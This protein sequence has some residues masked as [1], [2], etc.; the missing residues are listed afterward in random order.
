MAIWK[1]AYSWMMDVKSVFSGFLSLKID[2]L[3]AI[4]WRVRYQ[5][6]NERVI[7][8]QIHGDDDDAQLYVV[9]FVLGFCVA[10]ITGAMAM[11]LQ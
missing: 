10:C 3:K 5:S 1:A 2:D 7:R 4:F 8:A 11:L 9:V 6:Q